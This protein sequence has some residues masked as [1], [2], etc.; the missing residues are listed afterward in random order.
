MTPDTIGFCI[1]FFGFAFV[2]A[3]T[4]FVAWLRLP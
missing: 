2:I 4:I 3:A 1:G